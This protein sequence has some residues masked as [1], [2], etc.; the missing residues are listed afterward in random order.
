VN[1]ACNALR[2]AHKLLQVLLQL[3]LS[4]VNSVPREAPQANLTCC[5]YVFFAR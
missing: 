4:G 1:I 5:F 2:I 3:T